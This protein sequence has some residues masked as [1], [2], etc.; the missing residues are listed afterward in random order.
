M[1][2]EEMKQKHPNQ[3]QRYA[4]CQNFWDNKKGKEKDEEN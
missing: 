4:V 3:D 2:D 1:S